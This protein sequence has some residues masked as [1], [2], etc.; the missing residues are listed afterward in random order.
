MRS[1]MPATNATKNWGGNIS[2][3]GA[4]VDAPIELDNL[5]ELVAASERCRVLGSRH[6]FNTISDSATIIDTRNLP[7]T[8]SVADDRSDV[9]VSGWATYAWL[10]EQLS[11]HGLALKNM[12]S[13]PHI[14]VAGAIAT[15]THGSGNANQNLAA[16]VSGLRL[17]RSDGELVELRR[18][19]RDF[20]GAVVGLGALGLTVDVTLDVVPTFDLEQRVFD[21]PD[22]GV[23]AARVD[24]VFAAGYSVSVFTEWAGRADQIWVK[25]R[26]GD[27]TPSQ[28]QE[29]LDSLTPAEVRRHPVIEL[30]ASGCTEQLG[31]PGPWFDRLP[32]FQMGFEP[33]VGDEIQS[34]FFVHRMHAAEAIDAMARIGGD[35]SEALMIGE[36]RTVAAD[37]LWMSPHHGRDSLAF[38]FTWHP[39]PA[40]ADAAA[41]AVATALEPFAVRPHWGKVFAH[42]L[43]DLAQYE[44]AHQFV[45]LVERFDPTGTFRNDLSSPSTC[46]TGQCRQQDER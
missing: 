6:S 45:E 28:S 10:A 8:F 33:S 36:I 27:D 9:T 23:L 16:S 42:D 18:G 41:R 43:L 19:D 35:I 2:L 25:Q 21:G 11:A 29:L 38:H 31:A 1:D 24:D 46:A 37:S 14:S 5:C 40:A 22:L 39:D 30:D 17:I 4:I 44:N 7:T 26:V 13:L 15:G 34:E 32:H 20:D 3:S 12:A